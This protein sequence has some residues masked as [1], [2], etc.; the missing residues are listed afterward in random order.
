MIKSSGVRDRI[1]AAA[2]VEFATL[3]YAG[4]SLNRIV[5]AAGV[6][7]PMV[8]Y[9]FGSKAG[10]Y[11]HTLEHAVSFAASFVHERMQRALTSH[12]ALHAL[13]DAL[14]K[15]DRQTVEL[16]AD[17]QTDR[18]ATPPLDDI[19]TAAIG[20]IVRPGVD[21]RLVAH[22]IVAAIRHQNRLSSEAMPSNHNVIADLLWHGL[23]HAHDLPLS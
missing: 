20:S 5:A 9:Y 17:T 19:V 7:K 14:A 6:T 22:L 18:P 11:Q 10:L 15:L 12:A 23:Q 2:V 4:A 16:L 1:M 3:K 13:V 8:H 21:A